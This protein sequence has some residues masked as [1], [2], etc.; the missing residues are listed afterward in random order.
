MPIVTAE[1]LYA[2]LP[3][4]WGGNSDRWDEDKG[5]VFAYYGKGTT[6]RDIIDG[7][8]DD[9]LGGGDC[10]SLPDEVT[11]NDVRAA[12]LASLTNEGRADYASGA[13]S[14]LADH[15]ADANGLDRCRDCGEKVGDSHKAICDVGKYYDDIVED[16]DCPEDEGNDTPII[17]FLIRASVCDECGALAEY[18]TDELCEACARKYG[19]EGEEG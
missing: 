5:C 4:F 1:F 7:A 2:G 16:E 14:Y 6:V 10:D 19:Y 15:Y 13:V 8:V 17:V 11:D 3:D 12:L 18:H 9:F